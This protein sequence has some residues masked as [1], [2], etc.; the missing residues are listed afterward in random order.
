MLTYWLVGF[1]CNLGQSLRVNPLTAEPSYT[2]IGQVEL[3]LFLAWRLLPSPL[4]K[5]SIIF[6][7]IYFIFENLDIIFENLEIIFEKKIWNSH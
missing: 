5:I 6:E 2:Q 7:N 3:S 4:Q 1:G